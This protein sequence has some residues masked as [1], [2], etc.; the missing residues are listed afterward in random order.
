MN[1][2]LR[3]VPQRGRAGALRAREMRPAGERECGKTGEN[4]QK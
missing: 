3:A 2:L 4:G 1:A